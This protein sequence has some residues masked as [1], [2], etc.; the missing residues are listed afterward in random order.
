MICRLEEEGLSCCR[1]EV[2]LYKRAREE[3]GSLLAL[4]LQASHLTALSHEALAYKVPAL[5]HSQLLLLLFIVCLA[6]SEALDQSREQS[7]PVC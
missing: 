4:C 5:K 6:L 7:Q 2:L 3:K 1:Q